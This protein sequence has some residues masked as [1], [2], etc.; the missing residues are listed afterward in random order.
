MYERLPLRVAGVALWPD[1]ALQAA[2]P[3]LHL[4]PCPGSVTQ[5]S[6]LDFLS[7]S[8]S[9][10]SSCLLPPQ[11]E[12]PSLEIRSGVGEPRPQGMVAESTV[13]APCVGSRGQLGTLSGLFW[14]SPRVPSGDI[15]SAPCLS[16]EPQRGS[17]DTCGTPSRAPGPRSL[18]SGAPAANL[19][20]VLAGD[21]AVRG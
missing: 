13:W 6:W 1:R 9:L 17:R 15:P 8:I 4:I 7:W 18:R 11:N 5:T 20:A 10:P 16:W 19:A 3:L 12:T 2:L 14:G 21:L